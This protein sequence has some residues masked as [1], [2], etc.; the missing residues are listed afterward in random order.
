MNYSMKRIKWF[1]AMAILA[2]LL[3][4]CCDT[5][6]DD[7]IIKIIINPDNQDNSY[8]IDVSAKGVLTATSGLLTGLNAG[9]ISYYNLME[10]YEEE[11]YLEPGTIREDISVELTDGQIQEI[12]ELIREIPEIRRRPWP[13]GGGEDCW[14]VEVVYKGKVYAFTTSSGPYGEP[15]QS[16][17]FYRSEA[18]DMNMKRESSSSEM[19]E[20][21]ETLIE[22]STLSIVQSPPLNR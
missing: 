12:T 18:M 10:R 4:G 20:L 2:T 7:S 16:R 9:P 13:R 21:I 8:F 17:P 14:F 22:Y 11:V 5:S 3:V 1:F 15:F 6:Q 19:R